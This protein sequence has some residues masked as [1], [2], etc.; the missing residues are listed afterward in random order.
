MWD[1][2]AEEIEFE[3]S[4]IR[5]LLDEYEGLLQSASEKNSD[6]RDILALAGVL[7]CFY[8]GIENIFKRIAGKIDGG[9]PRNGAWHRS[10]LGSMTTETPNRPAV[11]SPSLYAQIEEYLRF[12]HRF[13]YLY[14]FDLNWEEMSP[15]ALGC[16]EM[17]RLLEA[18][19]DEFLKR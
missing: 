9:P 2:L 17:L 7:H 8:N 4:Q 19:L 6:R 14:S 13:R 3:L 5:R 15:L 18:E 12:R 1:E 11:I 16:K 10:L